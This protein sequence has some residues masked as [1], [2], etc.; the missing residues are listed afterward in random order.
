MSLTIKLKIYIL[1]NFQYIDNDTDKWYNVR[2]NE[3]K[4]NY[5]FMT[6]RVYK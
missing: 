3:Q 2:M 5:G 1:I 6:K 4:G